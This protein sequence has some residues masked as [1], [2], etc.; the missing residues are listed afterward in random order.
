MEPR[1]HR[2]WPKQLPW[3]LTYPQTSLYY[4][5]E[6]SATRYPDKPWLCYYDTALTFRQTRGQVDALAAFLQQRC[7]VERGDRV[8]LFMQNS[9]QF[10]VAYYAILRADAVVVPSIR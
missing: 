1:H 10:I 6:V 7:H 4:N 8:L 9:P 3:S 2:F 5:L